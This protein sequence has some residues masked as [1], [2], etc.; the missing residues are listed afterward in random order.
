MTF[1]AG[2]IGFAPKDTP[3]SVGLIGLPQWMWVE[4]PGPA[5]IGPQTATAAAGPYSVTATARVVDIVWDMGD[6]HT[7]TCTGPGT[8]YQQRYGDK[9]SPTCGYRYTQDGEYP[10][11]ATSNWRLDWRGMGQSGV[12]TFSVTR[13]TTIVMG[14]LQVIRIN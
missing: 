10:V 3:G 14:E 1:R 11:A 12:I 5:T 2:Q 9:E 13:T 6:G 8:P 4:D 7:V